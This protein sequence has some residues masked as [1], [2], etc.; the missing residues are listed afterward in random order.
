MPFWAGARMAVQIIYFS[1]LMLGD[2][3]H[4]SYDGSRQGAQNQ[5]KVVPFPIGKATFRRPQAFQR[6]I[7][8]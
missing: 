7:V 8:A 2:I 1:F 5:P 6:S 3:Y 4:N